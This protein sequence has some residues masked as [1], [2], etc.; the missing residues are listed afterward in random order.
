MNETYNNVEITPEE[1]AG[2]NETTESKQVQQTEATSQEATESP[3]VEDV[4]DFSYEEVIIEPKIEIDGELYNADQ[5]K[6]WMIDSQNKTEWQ[7]SNT[8]KAQQLSK[9]NKLVEKINTDSS[10]KDHI[11]DYFYDN[12]DEFNSLG[13]DEMAVLKSEIPELESV[14]NSTEDEGKSDI[15]VRLEN[16]ENMSNEQMEERRVEI[17]DANLT[18]LEKDNPDL[19]GTPEAVS[20]FLEFCEINSKNYTDSEGLPDMSRMFRE[21]SYDAKMAELAHLKKL[22][23][24][25]ERNSGKFISKSQNGAKESKSPTKYKSFKEVSM[26]DPEIAKYFE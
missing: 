7:K 15:E 20:E 2:L 9:M 18:T 5:A 25:R 13:L 19:L 10:F 26:N 3:D 6:E 1:M 16:L 12:P 8:E 24:N 14:D 11:K 17:L 21:W 23:N 4:G 22:N